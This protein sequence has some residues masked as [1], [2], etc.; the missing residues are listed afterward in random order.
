MQMYFFMIT[1][2][3]FVILDK[4]DKICFLITLKYHLDI[5]YVYKL[6]TRR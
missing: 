6:V 3:L 1:R 5:I 2:N 4:V